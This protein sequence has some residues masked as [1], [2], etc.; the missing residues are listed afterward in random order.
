MSSIPVRA[1]AAGM[2]W[3]RVGAGVIGVVTALAGASAGS[4]TAAPGPAG[5]KVVLGSAT[6][7][8]AYP[9]QSNG[10]D[11]EVTVLNQGTTVVDSYTLTVDTTSLAGIADLR[12]SADCRTKADRVLVCQR[13]RIAS[14]GD[15]YQ[16]PLRRA[17][18]ALVGASGEIRM[19]VESHGVQ[20]ASRT[21]K[22]TVPDAGL[23]TDRLERTPGGDTVKPGAAMKVTSG[24]TNYGATPLDDTYVVM[25][26]SDLVPGQEFG[27]CEYGLR[28]DATH[29]GGRAVCDVKGRVDVNGSYDLDLGSVKADT[30][31]LSGSLSVSYGAKDVP[32]GDEPHHRGTGG[33]LKL[34]PRPAS[35]PTTEPR[36][37]SATTTVRVDNTADIQAVGTTVRQKKAGDQVRATVGVRNKGPAGMDAWTGSEPGEDPPFETRVYL[38]AGTE[39]VSTPESCVKFTKNGALD[40]YLCFQDTKDLWIDPGQYTTWTFDLR[41]VRPAEL[42]PGR[43]TVSSLP[44]DP[45]KGDNTAAITIQA[46]GTGTGTGGTGGKGDGSGGTATGGTSAGGGDGNGAGTGGGTATGGTGHGSMA[47]TGTSG[48]VPLAAGASVVAVLL[49]GALFL[50]FRRRRQG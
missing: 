11:L 15:T 21:V 3:A 1:G 10:S 9:Y 2:R 17:K 50:G 8:S 16:L 32:W 35:A 7:L 19:T 18:G 43:I 6:A 44:T 40:H 39:A 37:G 20:L 28:G 26:Y 47:D 25:R 42:K 4:A 30:A 33:E 36:G 22:V 45:D 23:V 49:G 38:P 46:P 13:G 5:T 48:V 12:T 14:L 24:F 27:N 31:V 41:V 29:G 34:T